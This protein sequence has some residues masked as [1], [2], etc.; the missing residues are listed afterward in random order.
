MEFACN[1]VRE[2]GDFIRPHFAKR[3][4]TVAEKSDRSPLTEADTGAEALIRTRIIE[5]FPEHAI[6][7]EEM[8]DKPANGA[9]PFRWVIDPI[10]G[11]KSF[12]TGVPLFT[13]LLALEYE[14]TPIIGVIF[15]PILDQLVSSDGQTTRYNGVPAK[16]RS[17][18]SLAQ[19]TLLTTDARQ[20]C[21]Y[22]DDAD[23][24]G[25]ISAVKLYRTWGDAYGYLLL[26]AG[27]ADIMIDPILEHW[28]KAALLPILAGAGITVSDWTGGPAGSGRSLIAA[29]AELHPL[30]LAKLHPTKFADP[31]A[32]S[33]NA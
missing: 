9:S 18:S 12:I 26:V 15:Q 29:A 32:N 14:G 4:L 16:A 20:P 25:L 31:S 13:T 21:L 23:W 30:I 7:G 17:C 3:G 11:T 27:F 8:S 24:D 28:D 33:A 2:A 19:A 1:V 5:Q 22:Q 10:D 6:L